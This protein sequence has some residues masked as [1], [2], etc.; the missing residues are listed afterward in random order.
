MLFGNEH[1]ITHTYNPV[2][3]DQK[4]VKV[5]TKIMSKASMVEN[6][7]KFKKDDSVTSLMI[8]GKNDELFEWNKLFKDFNNNPNIKKIVIE[9][10]THLGIIF[11][12][13]TADYITEW[14]NK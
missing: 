3:N 8:I 5:Y 12:S 2:G 10:E 14:I 13:V 6:Y 4:I 7:N 9:N 1:E 11:N